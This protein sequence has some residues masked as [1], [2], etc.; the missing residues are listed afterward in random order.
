M[1]WWKDPFPFPLNKV[2]P[3]LMDGL[4]NVQIWK[5]ERKSHAQNVF[6]DI[7]NFQCSTMPEMERELSRQ[8]IRTWRCRG[9]WASFHKTHHD[10]YK[11]K[12]TGKRIDYPWHALL[13]NNFSD[14]K[15]NL[16]HLELHDR[17]NGRHLNP[18]MSIMKNVSFW[19]QTLDRF[20]SLFSQ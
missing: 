5:S 16:S 4:W 2:C 6:L 17:M 12:V 13:E 11:P 18:L 19:G 9:R 20:W 1:L 10:I 3:E 14:G 15:T 8:N 7:I